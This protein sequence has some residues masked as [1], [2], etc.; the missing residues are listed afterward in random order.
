M[1]RDRREKELRRP[2][3]RWFWDNVP[4]STV[5]F[6]SYIRK[7]PFHASSVML[8]P[9]MDRNPT[10]ESAFSF[11]EERFF[12]ASW[13]ILMNQYANSVYASM[14]PGTINLSAQKRAVCLLLLQHSVLLITP[15]LYQRLAHAPADKHGWSPRWFSCLRTVNGS[16]Q[17][18]H[19]APPLAWYSW[20]TDMTVAMWTCWWV[21]F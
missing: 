13:S 5:V 10:L 18:F 9:I 14:I 2:L 1:S 7:T 6:T 17:L 12:E 21:T 16:C 3:G 8:C 19:K 4:F 15:E 20:G 11:F